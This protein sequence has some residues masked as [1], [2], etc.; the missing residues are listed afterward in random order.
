MINKAPQIDFKIGQTFQANVPFFQYNHFGGTV[1]IV[2]IIDEPE[3][4]NK[5]V[6]PQVVFRCYGKHQQFW[7]YFIESKPILEFYIEQVKKFKLDKEYCERV[8]QHDALKSKQK[9]FYF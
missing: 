9:G 7:H 1:H 2:A 6:G 8:K 3:L 4:K 5:Y